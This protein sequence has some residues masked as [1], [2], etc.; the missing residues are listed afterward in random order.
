MKRQYGLTLIELLITVSII[1]LLLTVALPSY[2][3]M[4]KDSKLINTMNSIS[5]ITLFARGEA[6]KRSNQIIVCRSS[7][8]TSCSATG[9]N[10]IVV[11]DTDNNS[12]FSVAS[13]QLLKTITLIAPNSDI[14]IYFQEHNNSLI[15]F[16]ALGS[17]SNAG[18]IEVC[19]QRGT[20]K[21]KASMLNI[22][23]QLRYLDS[24][25]RNQITCAA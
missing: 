13:D 14:A 9:G 22:G 1:A 15:V 12:V 25:E 18:R 4:S 24:S 10:I 17:P 8:N 2:S 6:I 5:A 16:S 21:A 7:N 23:G 19:D 20:P 3:S 11:S